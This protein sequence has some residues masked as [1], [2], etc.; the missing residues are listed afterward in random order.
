MARKNEIKTLFDLDHPHSHAKE[1]Y[2]QDVKHNEM[3]VGLITKCDQTIDI[4]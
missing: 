1:F 3:I 4:V 2:Q